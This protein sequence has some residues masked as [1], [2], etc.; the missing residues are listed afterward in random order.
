MIPA[1]LGPSR[2]TALADGA[3]ARPLRGGGSPAPSGSP[4]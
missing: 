3:D 1:L 2:A 4:A